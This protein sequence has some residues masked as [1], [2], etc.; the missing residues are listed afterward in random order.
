LVATQRLLLL[1]LLLL[2]LGKLAN[3]VAIFFHCL[4]V[5]MHSLCHPDHTGDCD[6]LYISLMLL[7]NIDLVYTTIVPSFSISG[8]QFVQ[9]LSICSSRSNY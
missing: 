4:G 5:L 8:T 7:H 2:L 9:A 6:F 3:S 1:L